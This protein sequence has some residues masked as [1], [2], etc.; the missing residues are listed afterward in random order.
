TRM[1]SEIPK[2]LHHLAGKTIL[3]HVL[4]KARELASEGNI[5]VVCGHN[6]ELVQKEFSLENK[7]QWVEQDTQLG[8]AH[9]VKQALTKIQNLKLDLSKLLVL[10]ADVP[11]VAME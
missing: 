2:V 10:Y 8:T 4:D 11:L 1:K 5:F 3:A 7:F 9:A 6:K